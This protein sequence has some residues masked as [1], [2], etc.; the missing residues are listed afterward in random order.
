MQKKREQRMPTQQELMQ[1]YSQVSIIQKIVTLQHIHSLYLAAQQANPPRK[2]ISFNILQLQ[3]M[4]NN[5]PLINPD[6]DLLDINSSLTSIKAKKLK[7]EKIIAKNAL[8]PI[9][10]VQ[11]IAETLSIDTN[12]QIISQ[13]PKTTIFKISNKVTHNLVKERLI[14]ILNNYKNTTL[15]EISALEGR[16]KQK[17]RE[18]EMIENGKVD[19]KILYQEFV[20][21]LQK[22]GQKSQIGNN[23]R[24][25][26]TPADSKT[27]LASP[28]VTSKS[29]PLLN[30]GKRTPTPP[31]DTKNMTT[32]Q[33]ARALAEAQTKA[34]VQS[35]NAAA[36]ARQQAELEA[37]KKAIEQSKFKEQAQE[38]SSKIKIFKGEEI[39]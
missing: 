7:G 5:N 18:I 35:Q 17:K 11:V 20:R 32:E 30:N 16:Y 25:G 29:S 23:M 12:E 14:R 4:I 10:I 28:T 22:P 21:T 31:T 13:V 36:L 15:Q 34:H 27:P 6:F 2:E 3:N 9:Q 8:T 1:M 24:Q 33:K 19:D 26:S 37:Q 38:R 39:K